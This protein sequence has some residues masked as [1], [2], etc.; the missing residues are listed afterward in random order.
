M[1]VLYLDPA[2]KVYVD[3]MAAELD[4][5][6]SELV[7]ESLVT[8]DGERSS[9]RLKECNLGNYGVFKLNDPEWVQL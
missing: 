7:G 6:R 3:R 9:C 5:L 2:T 1:V 4:A 8:L